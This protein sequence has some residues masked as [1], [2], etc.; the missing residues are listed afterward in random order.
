MSPRE[1]NTNSSIQEE[2]KS[3]I[4]MIV[5]Y[6]IKMIFAMLM[7]MSKVQRQE[8]SWQTQSSSK[9][10]KAYFDWSSNIKWVLNSKSCSLTRSF[11][12]SSKIVKG[13]PTINHTLM[14]IL[15]VLTCLQECIDG[16]CI[17]RDKNSTNKTCLKQL[18]EL[19]ILL[20]DS[21]MIY[22]LAQNSRTILLLKCVSS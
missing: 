20:Y 13:D 7:T 22:V 9:Y 14:S 18:L 1:A 3:P 8:L 17:I 5:P 15:G 2:M 11:F 19:F 16:Q 21:L 12:F 4:F 6:A 10:V